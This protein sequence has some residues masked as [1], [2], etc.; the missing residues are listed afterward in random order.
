MPRRMRRGLMQNKPGPNHP[1][2]QYRSTKVITEC[3]GKVHVKMFLKTL[4]ESWDTY[5]II[6][7]HQFEG[8]N[9]HKLTTLPQKKIAAW[10]AGVLRRNYV[11]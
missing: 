1:W 2:R 11:E 3:E 5:E 10:L 6:T 4:V 7:T 9:R 8:S